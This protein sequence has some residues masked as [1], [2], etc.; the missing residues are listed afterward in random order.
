MNRPVLALV[1][2]SLALATV[3]GSSTPLLSNP[4]APS[5]GLYLRLD[6][7]V[8]VDYRPTQYNAVVPVGLSSGGTLL[9]HDECYATPNADWC[10]TEMAGTCTWSPDPFP[11]NPGPTD[12]RNGI[13]VAARAKSNGS[14]A[15]FQARAAV[16]AAVLSNPASATKLLGVW[17]PH[18]SIHWYGAAGY[19]GD[20]GSKNP[21]V[22]NVDFTGCTVS[23][24]GQPVATTAHWLGDCVWQP[25]AVENIEDHIPDGLNGTPTGFHVYVNLTLAGS[26]ESLPT[27]VVICRD[28]FTKDP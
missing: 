18:V 15:W 26:G 13:C 27:A 10:P 3:A 20:Q 24:E 11:P 9:S 6:D 14:D 12:H 28:C 25:T 23:L 2:L 1:L 7:D 16:R 8:I 4:A 19:L 22:A 17:E 21:S 5:A